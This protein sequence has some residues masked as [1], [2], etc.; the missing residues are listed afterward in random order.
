MNDYIITN[1]KTAATLTEENIKNSIDN[2]KTDEERSK[3][4]MLLKL[5][6]YI[7]INNIDIEKINSINIDDIQTFVLF[8]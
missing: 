7:N 2:A 4:Q 3:G 5:K 8:N 1:L 6:Q